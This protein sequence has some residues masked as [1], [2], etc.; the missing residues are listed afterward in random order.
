MESSDSIKFSEDTMF[1]LR[2]YEPWMYESLNFTLINISTL[3]IRCSKM[4]I[5]SSFPIS[6]TN[7]PRRESPI[8]INTYRLRSG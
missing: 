5:Q 8:E 4:I 6:W 1:S 7:V 2:V 3:F